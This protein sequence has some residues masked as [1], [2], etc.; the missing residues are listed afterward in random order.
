ML[1]GIG[2]KWYP[3]KGLIHTFLSIC[4]MCSGIACGTCPIGGKLCFGGS[5]CTYS[6]FVAPFF[7]PHNVGGYVKTTYP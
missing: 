5:N 2:A 6:H 7:M 4:S 3:W 1:L